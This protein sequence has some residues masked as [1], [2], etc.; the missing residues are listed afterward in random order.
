MKAA[1]KNRKNAMVKGCKSASAH[2]IIGEVA[3][4]TILAITR[5]RMAMCLLFIGSSPQ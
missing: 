5:A 2:F 4:Q 3:P 1:R